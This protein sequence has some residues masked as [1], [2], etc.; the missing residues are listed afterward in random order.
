MENTKLNLYEKIQ[1]V[2]NEVKSISKN[3]TVGTGNYSYKAVSDIDVTLAI[4]KAELKHRIV[5]IPLKQELINSEVVRTLKDNKEGLTY[6][7]T[8]KMTV[9]I[10]D[11]DNIDSF[12]EIESFG[13]GIDSGDKGFGKASTYARKYALLNAYKIATGEDPDSHKNNPLETKKTISD[14]RIAVVN[15]LNNNNKL[16]QETLKYLNIGVL[17]DMTE[18]NVELLYKTYTEKKLI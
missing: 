9:K 8:I 13:K 4:N 7:D 10:V 11:L 15:Y 6:V 17:E 18:A 2:S 14:K 3:M 5:S 16:L 12:I 1:L